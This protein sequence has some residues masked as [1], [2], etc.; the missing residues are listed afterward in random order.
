M[1]LPRVSVLYSNG[2]LLQDI[3][4]IDG[5]AGIAGT[6]D[7]IELIGKSVQVFNLL[8]AE[9]KGFTVAD[10]PFMHRHIKEFYDEVGGNQELWLYG[11]PETDTM[12]QSLDNED[13]TSAKNLIRVAGGKIRLLGV[14]RK[15]N[16]GYDPGNAFYD[17]DVEAAI[18]KSN[19]FCQARL[20]EL[21][22]LRILI[23]GR[24]A[25]DTSLDVFEPKTSSIGFA[26]V[27]V[28]GSANDGSASIGTALGRAVKF[29]RAPPQTFILMQRSIRNYMLRTPTIR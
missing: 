25:D 18:I 24:I 27:V 17:S 28:G 11:V 8:D 3:S 2:N 13:E 19:T 26:G 21:V 7:T 23:E 1:F 16:L 6:V 20:D 15:P 10:E 9:T 5:I 22:P 4:V 12:A 29:T 14:T